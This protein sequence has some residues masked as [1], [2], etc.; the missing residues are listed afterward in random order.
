[1]NNDEREKQDKEAKEKARAN[2]R[3][4]RPGVTALAAEETARLDQRI[5]EK[6]G[7]ATSTE[8][9]LDSKPGAVAVAARPVN[10]KSQPAGGRD[11][12]ESLEDRINAK[13]RHDQAGTAQ[14]ELESLE[15]AIAAKTGAARLP[16]QAELS[17]LDERI[18]AK[19]SQFAP[20]GTHDDKKMP[21]NLKRGDNDTDNKNKKGRVGSANVTMAGY[22]S[23]EAGNM[24]KEEEFPEKTAENKFGLDDGAFDEFD[25]RQRR[26]GGIFDPSDIEYGAYDADNAEGLAVAVPVMEEDENVFIP[27][28]VE[29]DPDAKPPLYHNRRFRLYAA[30]SVFIVVVLAVG[31]GVGMAHGNKGDSSG[32]SRGALDIEE[33]VTRVIGADLL[34]DTRSPYAKALRWITYSDPMA[35][36]TEDPNLMQR[37]IAAYFYYATSESRPWQSCNPPTEDEDEVC[38]YMRLVSITPQLTRSPVPGSIRWLSQESECKWIGIFCDE[39]DQIRSID[40]SKCSLLFHYANHFVL[41]LASCSAYLSQME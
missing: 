7:R 29:Y 27:S 24:K 31:F 9:Q 13:V 5:E 3:A 16:P 6:I 39:L 25:D 2:A 36:T 30:L 26:P 18:A 32:R 28:A 17:R 41:I 8:E 23:H 10:S 1:M 37:Y 4:S 40:L 15:D 14:A 19:T 35:L 38:E 11:A 34:E 21:P 12:I 20:N 33:L 22:G